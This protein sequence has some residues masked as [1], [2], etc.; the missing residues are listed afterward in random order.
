M[1]GKLPPKMWS[2][3]ETRRAGKVLL[4]GGGAGWERKAGHCLALEGVLSNT[5]GLPSHTQKVGCEAPPK[6][7]EAAPP[8]WGPLES[9]PHICRWWYCD[10]HPHLT[11]KFA[12]AQSEP[13]T[14]VHTGVT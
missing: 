10:F 9:S 13:T 8:A 5:K 7:V 3:G 1:C 12:E 6:R 4:W 2:P 11:G 14:Q